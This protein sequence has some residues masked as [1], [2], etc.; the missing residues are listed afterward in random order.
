MNFCLVTARV[1]STA[2]SSGG[3][4]TCSGDEPGDDYGGQQLIWQLDFEA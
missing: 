3:T 2:S 1:T 4:Q